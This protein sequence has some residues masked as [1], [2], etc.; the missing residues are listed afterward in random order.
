MQHRRPRRPLLAR[1]GF[2]AATWATAATLGLA[3]L[4]IHTPAWQAQ[5]GHHATPVAAAAPACADSAMRFNP[6]ATI[7]TSTIDDE[8]TRP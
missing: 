5:Y 1:T 2:I 3:L 7:D 8:R 6:C 4:G